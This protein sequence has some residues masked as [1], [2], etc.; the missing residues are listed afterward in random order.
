[1]GDLEGERAKARWARVEEHIG[2]ENRHDLEGVMA[3]FGADARFEDEPWNDRRIGRDAVRTYYTETLRALPDLAI[4]VLR[5]HPAPETLTLE[6]TISGTH[7]GE[8]RGLPATGRRVAF[9]LCAVYEFDADDR[10]TGE[11]VYYDRAAVLGQLGLFH[12]P[13][14]GWGRIAT[15]LSH[16]LTILRAYLGRGGRG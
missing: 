15:A 11:R 4:E 8:W 16:P 13:A 2:C 6:V 9:P 12:E 7:R 1:M 10:L 3:T 14:S 5:R